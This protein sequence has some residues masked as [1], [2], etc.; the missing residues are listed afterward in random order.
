MT[1]SSIHW[2]DIQILQLDRTYSNLPKMY[3]PRRENNREKLKLTNS[4]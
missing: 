3:M 4:P 2:E 1:N